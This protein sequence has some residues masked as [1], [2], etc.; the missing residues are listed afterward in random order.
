V[1]IIIGFLILNI[2]CTVWTKL[3]RKT[4]SIACAGERIAPHEVDEGEY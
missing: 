1:D 3:E 4:L 2:G